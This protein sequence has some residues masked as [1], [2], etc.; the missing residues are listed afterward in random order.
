LNNAATPRGNASMGGDIISGWKGLQGGFAEQSITSENA[1]VVK[2]QIEFVG[3]DAGDAYTVL[4][5]ALTYQ[6]SNSTLVNALTD[7]ATWSHK[8]NHFGYEFTPRT[9]NGTMANGG[10]GAG[11]VWTINNGNW[12]STWSNGGKPIIAVNQAPRNA[13]IKQGEYNFAIS[14]RSVDDITNKI[15]WYMIA[16]DNS[17]WFGGT[18]IDT[19][20]TKK[21]NSIIFGV[22]EV[23]F[24]QFNVKEMKVDLGSPITVPEAP[25]QAFYVDSW[26]FGDSRG[27]WDL[28]P[29][30]VVGNVSISGASP[31][32]DWS[33]VRGAFEPYAPKTDKALIVTGKM[34]FTNGGFEAANSLRFGLFYSTTAGNAVVDSVADSNLVWNGDQTHYS[35]YLMVPPSGT[36]AAPNWV[37]SGMAGT[38]GGVSDG[39]FYSTEGAAGYVLGDQMTI[40]ANTVGSAGTYEFKISVSKSGDNAAEV[41]FTL[42]GNNGYYWEGSATDNLMSTDKFN[43]IGFALNTNTTTGLDIM[44]VYVN[45]GDPIVLDV[46]NPDGT[47]VIPVSYSLNQNYPNPFN[48]ATTIEF[49]L[50]KD[51]DVKLAVYNILGR[52]ITQ[53]INI[54][55]K[56]GYHRVNFNAS[57]LSSG[58]YF[59]SLKAGDFTSVKKLV[60]MK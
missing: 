24:T 26:G 3:A 29:G 34:K 43:S 40:P 55:L 17:Y 8:G 54:D 48:P 14:V 28:T 23:E 5:Y 51:S 16:K 13:E 49:A 11:T 50:P 15:K 33:A 38:W 12:A 35:G 25:F 32:S 31:N 39:P 1:L 60:L 2:G 42:S 44:D 21:F 27:G 41:R 22:N 9:G 30:E 57:N 20:T 45:Y 47:S 58:I 52:E 46:E 7:S 56:A 36:N 19:S 18:V 10:G 59:Y 37:G 53:L 6:D 4:R